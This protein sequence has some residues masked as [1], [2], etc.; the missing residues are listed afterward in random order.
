MVKQVITD[1]DSSK[2]FGSNCTQ[3]VV[4]NIFEVGLSYIL[5]SLFIKCLKESFFQNARK[6][7]DRSMGKNYCPVRLISAV[8]KV[9]E[10]LK[11]SKLVDHLGKIW[12]FY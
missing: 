11:N 9:F 2:A 4:L 10:N 3:V 7:S 1:L 8:S 12:Y 5:V 6:F